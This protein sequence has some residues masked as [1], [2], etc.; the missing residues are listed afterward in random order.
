[1]TNRVQAMLGCEFQTRMVPVSKRADAQINARQ[2][3]SLA[4]AQF[5]ADKHCAD[6]IVAL[7]FNNFELDDPVIQIEHIP[8]LDCLGE[9][10]KAYRHL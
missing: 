7:H 3:E 9:L 10:F 4:G 2:V 8:G 1:M 5:A 6:Y